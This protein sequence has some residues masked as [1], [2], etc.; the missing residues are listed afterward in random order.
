MFVHSYEDLATKIA[1]T[2]L[3]QRRGSGADSADESGGGAG[4]GNDAAKSSARGSAAAQSR[5]LPLLHGLRAAVSASVKTPSTRKVAAAAS[6]PGKGARS[7]PPQ[8]SC[9]PFD[10]R[11]RAAELERGY[12]LALEVRA[13]TGAGAAL[14]HALQQAGAAQRMGDVGAAV[15]EGQGAGATQ[16]KGALRAAAMRARELRTRTRMHIVVGRSWHEERLFE[17]EGFRPSVVSDQDGTA[18]TTASGVMATAAA[19]DA[20]AQMNAAAEAAA[21]EAAAEAARARALAAALLEDEDDAY[22]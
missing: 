16:K 4:G 19:T 6:R 9:S 15:G 3:A 5:R 18:A 2:T 17:Y 8:H 7:P 10:V 13:A 11:A 1:T 20:A 12:L 14:Q 22:G 21:E